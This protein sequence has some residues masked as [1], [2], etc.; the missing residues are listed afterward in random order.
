MM[1]SI[2]ITLLRVHARGKEHQRDEE[3][4]VDTD[5]AGE[6]RLALLRVREKR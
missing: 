1:P 6:A 4:A 3:E 5:A 2:P